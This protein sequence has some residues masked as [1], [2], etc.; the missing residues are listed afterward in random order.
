MKKLWI[1]M[2]TVLGLSA[3]STFDPIR[4]WEPYRWN[5]PE[6]VIVNLPQELVQDVCLG[7]QVTLP[8]GKVL[9]CVQ[10]LGPMKRG[11]ACVIHISSDIDIRLYQKILRHE[12]AHCRGWQHGQL[13]PEGDFG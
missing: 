8:K 2:A 4:A 1:L 6:F 9:A 11:Q 5:E 12:K 3:C 13:V 10:E 7:G